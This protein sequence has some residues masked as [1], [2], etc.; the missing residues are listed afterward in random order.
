MSG[1]NIDQIKKKI[2]LRFTAYHI[3]SCGR[4]YIKCF[5][6]IALLCHEVTIHGMLL[7]CSTAYSE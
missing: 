3:I 7:A 6:N 1:K 4:C 5:G 2:F